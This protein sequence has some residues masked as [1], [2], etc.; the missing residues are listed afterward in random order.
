MQIGPRPKEWKVFGNEKCNNQG[1]GASIGQVE[2]NRGNK[3]TGK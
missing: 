3:V 2:P 1:N